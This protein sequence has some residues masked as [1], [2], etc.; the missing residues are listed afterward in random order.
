MKSAGSVNPTLSRADPPSGRRLVVR[1][2]QPQALFVNVA[3][4][5]KLLRRLIVL[6][7]GIGEAADA[8]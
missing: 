1:I 4:R 3:T 7:A 6:M 2:T 5:H 8:E